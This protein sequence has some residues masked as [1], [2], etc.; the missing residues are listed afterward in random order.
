MNKKFGVIVTGLT[1]A[2]LCTAAV[3][4]PLPKS[5]S[6]SLRSATRTAF[7][8]L[9]IADKLGQAH[10]DGRGVTFNDKDSGPLHLGPLD[11]TFASFIT[12][13]I[14]RNKGYC[15]FGDADGDRLFTEWI[16]T[17]S[18]IDGSSQGTSDI[19]GGTGKYAGITGNVPWKCQAAGANGETQ[20]TQRIDYKL[21]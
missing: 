3:A 1:L 12:K 7:E 8:I 17:F 13:D 10:G 14:G 9:P 18:L 16:G 20:C 2:A 4:D 15:A 5:G 21:P 11:C 19:V 6:I